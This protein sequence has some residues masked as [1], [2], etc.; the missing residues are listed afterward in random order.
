MILGFTGTRQGMT[1]Y[2][3]AQ[4]RRF[5]VA[6]QC[7]I[8]HHGDCIGADAQALLDLIDSELATAEFLQNN[9]KLNISTL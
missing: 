9:Y 6:Y 3:Q 8:L 7:T 5:L 4:V 2:Q 1:D